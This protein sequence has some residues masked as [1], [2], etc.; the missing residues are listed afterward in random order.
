MLVSHCAEV[1]CRWTHGYEALHNHREFLW[2]AIDFAMSPEVDAG[3][4]ETQ[5]GSYD[6]LQCAHECPDILRCFMMFL[7]SLLNFGRM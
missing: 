5:P 2:H 4:E 3:A 6:G 7:R 1:D